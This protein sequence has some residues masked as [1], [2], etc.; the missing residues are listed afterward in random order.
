M[1]TY[2]GLRRNPGA[3]KSI[4]G[5]TVEEFERLYAEFEP[6]WVAAEEA[7]LQRPERKR[8]MGGGNAYKLDVETQLLLVLVWLRLYLTTATLGYFFGIS[9]SAASRNTRRLLAV[10]HEVSDEAFGW[11]DPPRKG[12]GHTAFDLEEGYPDLFAI[13][14][15]TEQPLETPQEKEQEHLAYSPKRRR[16]TVKSSLIVNEDGVIRGLTPSALGRMHDLTQIRQSGLLAKIPPEVVVIADAAYVGLHNDLPDHS[17]AV[18]HKAQPK[19][20]LQQGHKDANREL[21]SVRIMVENVIC[22]LKHFQSLAL[23]FRHDVEQVHSAVFAVIAMLVN[24][25]TQRRLEVQNCA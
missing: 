14:D 3:F 17:V 21:S 5:I 7:R 9:Q 12:Q 4:A 16:S 6:A 11:P 23:R 8:A 18:A 20:P 25:R 22:Q 1:V 13:L 15:A 19:H 24:R 10:L 2:Y